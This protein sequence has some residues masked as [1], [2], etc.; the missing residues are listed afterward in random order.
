MAGALEPTTAMGTTR[1]KRLPHAQRL[2]RLCARAHGRDKSFYQCQAHRPSSRS[3]LLVRSMIVHGDGIRARARTRGMA[4][5]PCTHCHAHG[6]DK[7]CFISA[8]SQLPAMR[9]RAAVASAHRHTQSR[10]VHA[11]AHSRGLRRA[12]TGTGDGAAPCGRMHTL[13]LE[14]VQSH[15]VAIVRSNFPGMELH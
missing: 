3:S 7:R 11:L 13:A 6:C 15:V 12:R 5:G 1:C 10:G 14:S 4:C 8:T 2:Q 9:A